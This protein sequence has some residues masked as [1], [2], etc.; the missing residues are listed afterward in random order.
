VVVSGFSVFDSEAEP[1]LQHYEQLA[2]MLDCEYVHN[3]REMTS[4]FTEIYQATRGKKSF[5]SAWV[6]PK[7]RGYFYPIERIR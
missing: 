5:H 4:R 2:M 3:R 6:D 7:T 1:C